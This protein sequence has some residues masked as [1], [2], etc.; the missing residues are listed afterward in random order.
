MRSNKK[1]WTIL[2][3]NKFCSTTNICY[4][5]TYFISKGSCFIYLF[6]LQIIIFITVKCWLFSFG[7][8]YKC[9]FRSMSL[10]ILPFTNS[11]ELPALYRG[12]IKFPLETSVKWEYQ[13]HWHAS[14]DNRF[15]LTPFNGHF[16]MLNPHQTKFCFVRN[17]DAKFQV[18][19]SNYFYF[20]EI[21]NWSFIYDQPCIWEKKR[22][23]YFPMKFLADNRNFLHRKMK[24]KN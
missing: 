1:T 6:S 22:M 14:G 15:V 12:A 9:S 4:G 10:K 3:Y 18:L 13:P 19:M 11:L 20:T 7:I 8:I 16:W 24:Q 17:I 21:S 5:H 2:S 23:L